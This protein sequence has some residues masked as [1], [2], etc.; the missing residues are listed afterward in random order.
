MELVPFCIC[1][2]LYF[3]WKAFHKM[4]TRYSQSPFQFIPKVSNQTYP[5]M[6]LWTLLRYSHAGMEKG[7]PKIVPTNLEA[8]HCPNCL[9]MLKHTK[10]S[11][12]VRHLIQ[13]LKNSL[14]PLFLLHQSRGLKRKYHYHINSLWVYCGSL[15]PTLSV[16]LKV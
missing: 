6:S 11:L 10:T 5:P 4:L 1:N 2:C 7:L 14:I 12:E 3:S 13:L 16:L 9:G 8:W 15:K